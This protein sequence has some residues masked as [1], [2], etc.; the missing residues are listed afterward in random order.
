MALYPSQRQLLNFSAL[1]FCVDATIRVHY[2][3]RMSKCF[4]PSTTIVQE[5][6]C[7]ELITRT[8]P[9][10]THRVCVDSDE[11]ET[12][13]VWIRWYDTRNGELFNTD[14]KVGLKNALLRAED[15]VSFWA[16][17]LRGAKHHTYTLT[18]E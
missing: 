12:I 4:S 11:Y 16:R 2:C 5:T 6:D 17:T 15:I 14:Y 13:G 7:A 10:V 8:A 18:L 1:K 9:D 3:A